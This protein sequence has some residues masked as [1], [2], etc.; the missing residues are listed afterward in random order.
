[1]RTRSVVVIAMPNAMALDIICPSDVFHNA[2][3]MMAMDK[4]ANAVSYQVT[5]VSPTKDLNVVTSSG[6]V[7]RCEKTIYEIESRID[8]L[9]IGGFSM[10]YNWS[11]QPDL[12]AWLKENYMGIRR[13][14]AVCIGAFVLA[15]AG[16][17]ESKR[18]TTH[19]L[20]AEDLKNKYKGIL[21]NTDPIFVKDQN[22]YTSGGATAG[23]DLS[24]ALVEEDNGREM[25][26]RVAKVLVL[27]LKRPGNQ[28]QFS[29]ILLHQEATKKPIYDLQQW[30]K[31]NLREDLRVKTL[32]ERVF[33]SERNFA[34]V[35]YAE[36][37]MTPCQIY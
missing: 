3:R 19:W 4:T 5:I 1:M 32:A 30:I 14:S 26:L 16:L 6:L 24:L 25:A 7:I 29:D 21:V 23:I 28:S 36:I 10:D 22:I 27:Y 9:I 34:R 13:L 8:T 35:F 31:D 18:A 2:N 11:S 33:M 17:L 12:V 15:E 37:G 20:N